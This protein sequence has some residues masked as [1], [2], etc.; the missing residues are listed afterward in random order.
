LNL[1]FCNMNHD[2]YDDISISTDALDYKFVSRGPKGNQ[3]KLVKFEPHHANDKIYNLALATI[4][5]GG[6]VDFNSPSNNG[7]RD[8]IL[9]TIGITAYIFSKAYPKRMIFFK[10][11]THVKTRLYQMAINNA[12][13][14]INQTFIIHGLKKV[15]YK[16]QPE[17]FEKGV[18]YDGFLFQRR[19]EDEN[20]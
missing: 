15:D 13:E 18:N 20:D 2:K 9:A 12:L 19:I 7:D 11:D 4:K 6:E 10:G 8:K 3:D 14:E 5:E 1:Y 16:Y 17:A